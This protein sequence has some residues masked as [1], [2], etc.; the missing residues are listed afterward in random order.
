MQQSFRASGIQRLSGN[1]AR[2]YENSEI[3]QGL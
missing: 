2:N 3:P 1:S